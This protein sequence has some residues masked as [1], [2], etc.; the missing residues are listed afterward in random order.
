[1]RKTFLKKLT[2]IMLVA[3]MAVGMLGVAGAAQTNVTV[4]INDASAEDD[5]THTYSAY[6]IFIGDYDASTKVLSNV[7]WGNAVASENLLNALKNDATLGSDFANATTA[8]DVADVLGN[9]GENSDELKIFAKLARANSYYAAFNSN[10]TDSITITAEGYYLIED[11]S[12]DSTAVFSSFILKVVGDDDI[13]VDVKKSLPTLEKT[14]ED[15]DYA[16]GD[17]VEFVLTGTVANNVNDF[18]NYY[19]QFND[20]L[21]NGLTFKNDVV[22]KIDGVV[23]DASSYVV[24][25]NGQTF[26]VT[27]S[28]LKAA[29]VGGQTVTLKSGNETSV[30]TVTYTATLNENAVIGAEG[31]DNT[32]SLTYSNN[33]NDSDGTDDPTGDTPDDVVTVYSYPVAI[34]KYDGDDTNKELLAD[35]KFKL[36]RFAADG[37]TKEYAVFGDDG[38]ITDWNSTGSEITTNATAEV[39]ISGLDADVTYYLEETKAPAGYNKLDEDYTITLTAYDGTNADAAFGYVAEVANN[40]GSSLPS[41]GGIGTTILYIVGGI[42]VVGAGVTLVVRKRMQNEAE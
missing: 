15:T 6:Q 21:S 32:A 2:A 31:N 38:K 12:T 40:M 17:D 24:T 20:E 29:T 28:N 36:Y 18:T 34:H 23:V 7:A 41:T 33:P 1:M 42:L 8:Q 30:V 11:S 9:Y 13:T 27:F 37:I 16:I 25:T 26:T 35:A 3:M 10:G 5:A 22:V 4:T 19:F 39:S 14:V